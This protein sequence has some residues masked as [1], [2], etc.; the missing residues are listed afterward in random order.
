M[1]FAYDYIH[2]KYDQH[3]IVRRAALFERPREVLTIPSRN[4]V[5]SHRKVTVASRQYMVLS[6]STDWRDAVTNTKVICIS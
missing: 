5:V 2:V 3:G 1:D 4:R 6:R